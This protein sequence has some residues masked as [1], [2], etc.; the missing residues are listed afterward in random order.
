MIFAELKYDGHY[1]DQHGVVVDVLVRQFSDVKWG[2]QGDSWIAVSSGESS[3]TVD[4][5]S[6]WTHQVKAETDCELVGQVIAALERQFT[7][8][9]LAQP[10][11]EIHEEAILEPEFETDADAQDT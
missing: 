2:H 8:E 10:E 7:V 4:T 3:V 11:L 5:F 6:A 9:V 1:D